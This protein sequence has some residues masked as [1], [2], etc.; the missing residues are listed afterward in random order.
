MLSRVLLATVFSVFLTNL[1]ASQGCE[2]YVPPED[3]YEAKNHE[4]RLEVGWFKEWTDRHGE[5]LPEALQPL[6]KWKY[7]YTK[8]DY[9]SSMHEDS[10][11][12]DISN[13]Q[14]PGPENPTV[15]Y[16]QVKEQLIGHF[17]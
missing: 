7:P 10:Y 4:A 13:L 11:A 2:D 14:G 8:Q 16:F 17:F 6:E 15:Q 9:A 3:S 12:S 1:V 5:V